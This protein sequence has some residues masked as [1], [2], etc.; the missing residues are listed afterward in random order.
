MNT[1]P[2]IDER[3]LLINLGDGKESAFNSLYQL[4]ANKIYSRLL[5]LTQS[6]QLADELLQDT[7]IIL[8]NKRHTINPDLSIKSWLYKVAENEVYQLYRKIARDKKL[9]EHIV[10]TFIETYSHTEEGIFYKESQELL[11]EAMEQ[12]TPQ[13]KEAF[14]LCRIEGMSYQEAATKMGVSVSTVSNHLVQ[15]T[16]LVRAYIFRSKESICSLLIAVILRHN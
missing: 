8:W 14:K 10:S 5:K 13:R 2:L 3:K 9:Q 11:A 16:N 12:L 4:Y 7:F 1:L 15:A 6:E